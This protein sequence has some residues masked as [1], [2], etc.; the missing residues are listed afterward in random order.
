MPP[1]LVSS[2]QLRSQ[3]N[4]SLGVEPGGSILI[5]TMTVFGAEALSSAN[6]TNVGSPAG[7]GHS[8]LRHNGYSVADM[9]ESFEL[10][11]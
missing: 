9:I 6:L 1:E 5:A 8:A 3:P 2:K 4:D 11:P 7:S 10:L